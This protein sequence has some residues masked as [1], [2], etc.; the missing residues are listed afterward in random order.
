MAV[1]FAAFTAVVGWEHVRDRLLA[2][3]PMAVRRELAVSS[4]HMIAAHP[5]SGVGLGAWP[6]VYP[7]YAVLDVGGFANQAHCD[8]LQWTAEG[9][10]PLGIAL[11]TLFG[12]CVLPAV[13]SVWGIGV[14]AVFLHAAVEYPFSR[15]A[16]GSWTILIIGMLAAR[17]AVRRRTAEEPPA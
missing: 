3:D 7:G 13:R 15:P 2:P 14:I 5:W 17:E 9:G 1:L 8:W 10:I 12:W 11:L 6:T 4:L 16:L